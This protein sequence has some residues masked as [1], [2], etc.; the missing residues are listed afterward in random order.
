MKTF[1]IFKLNHNYSEIAKKEPFKIYILLNSIYTYKRKD[2]IIAF[3]LFNEICLSI[4]KDFFNKY[5]Y[6]KLKS[7]DEY[8]RFQNVHMYHNYFTGEESKMTVNISHIK[9]KSN[10]DKNIFLENIISDL[11][12]CDFN[13]E[14][15]EYT[16]S[17]IKKIK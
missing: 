9:I 4:N 2:I 3:D 5:F 13:R 14:Y 17:N 15:Y 11:F 1:Y 12:I 7:D 16:M 10:L 6:D 8:I